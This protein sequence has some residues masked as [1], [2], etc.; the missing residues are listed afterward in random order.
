MPL[1]V[2]LCIQVLSVSASQGSLCVPAPKLFPVAFNLVKS[3]MGEETRRK[4]VIMGG[5]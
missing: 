3:F 5:E 1:A 4:M 2:T